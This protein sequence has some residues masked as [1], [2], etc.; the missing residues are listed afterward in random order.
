MSKSVGTVAIDFITGTARL[1][2]DMGK[3]V[4]A[5][6]SGRSKINNNLARMQRGFEGLNKKVQRTTKRMFSFKSVAASLVGSAGLGLVIKTSID[7]AD[8]IGKVADSANISTKK[9][10]ELRFAGDQYGATNRDIDDA[11]KRFNRRLGLFVQD[12]GG[13]AAK[14]FEQLGVKTK[15]AA[16][17]IRSTEDVLDDAIARLSTYQNKAEVAAVASQLFGEDAGPRLANLMAAGTDEMARLTQKANDLGL[18]MSDDMVRAAEAAKDKLSQLEML[19]R[20]KLNVTV[21]DNA[22][23]IG[24]MAQAVI[25][26][27]GRFA[28]FTQVVGDLS[29]TFKQEGAE[30]AIKQFSEGFLR[31]LGAVEK[32][33]PAKVRQVTDEVVAL[34][35]AFMSTSSAASASM[36]LSDYNAERKKLF[37]QIGKNGP[38]DQPPPQKVTITA[39]AMANEKEAKEAF[40]KVDEAA[41]D[42][43]E[44]I[45][46]GLEDMTL[47]GKMNFKDMTSSI[48]A[49]LARL[50]IKQAAIDPLLNIASGFVSSAV[51]SFFNPGASATGA[52]TASLPKRAMGGPVNAGQTY[53]VGERGPETF[54][55]TQSGYINPNGSGGGGVVV[56]QTINLSAGVPQLV[57]AEVRK[58]LPEIQRATEAGV[59]RKIGR[60]GSLARAVGAKS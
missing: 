52:E 22:E 32:S 31:F 2:G 56:N 54:T 27:I 44:N 5:V 4:A 40:E 1:K 18:I 11:V 17:N 21:A 13:P 43:L 6:S 9:L 49:D 19:I 36:A 59:Q 50:I 57:G 39:E 60:G 55:P 38:K 51:G 30:G 37:D 8:A 46:R 3:A 28:K 48:E 29:D 58:M 26:A 16:G 53:L 45:G 42:S 33:E 24:K 35:N 12:G 47:R 23:E 20:T 15:D 7:A 10:Q 25:D 14:A 41:Q 34:N